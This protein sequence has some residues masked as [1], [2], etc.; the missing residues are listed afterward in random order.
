M[1]AGPRV[2]F[3]DRMVQRAV[4]VEPL[5]RLRPRSRFEPEPHAVGA[6]VVADPAPVPLSDA[7]RRPAP[8]PAA[9]TPTAA[10]PAAAPPAEAPPTTAPTTAPPITENPVAANT[11]PVPAVAAPPP[12]PVLPP[13][14]PP[15]TTAR[16]APLARRAAR[17][18]IDPGVGDRVAIR[19]A[20]PAP[21]RPDDLTTPPTPVETATPEVAAPRPRHD[22]V[23]TGDLEA[24]AA[25]PSQPAPP[26]APPGRAQPLAPPDPAVLIRD[27]VVPVLIDRG[28][29]APAE[30]VVVGP[31]RANDGAPRRGVRVVPG[32]TRVRTGE[33]GRAAGSGEVHVHIERVEV[34]RPAPRPPAPTARRTPGA[35]LDAYLA[36][37]RERR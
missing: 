10:P 9:A 12:L 28:L 15:P 3:V 14:P 24:G 26:P 13:V 18:T 25:Q 27:H 19:P 34:Q 22:P 32:A 1:T 6:R 11:E 21:A 23:G 31:R 4:G 8:T 35:D 2:S 30:P 5:V 17:P 7:R 36:R 16:G 33:G 20:P 29:I 37:R